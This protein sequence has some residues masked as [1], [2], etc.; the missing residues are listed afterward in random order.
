MKFDCRTIVCTLFASM[1]ATIAISAEPVSTESHADVASANDLSNL[2]R[3]VA[4]QVSPGIVTVYALRGPRMTLPMRLRERA[5][6]GHQ[7]APSTYRP[8][9]TSP[10]D[11]P[12]DQGSGVVIDRD[13][14]VLT[15]SHV[16]ENANAVFVRTADGQK[17]HASEVV[18]D[19][20]SDLAIIK[21]KDAADLQEVKLADS[22]SLGVG[23]WVI[24]LT[25]PYDLQRSV[26]A[27]IINSTQR[28]VPSSPYPLIQNDACTN[29]GSS[30]GALLNLHGEVVGIIEG[31]V[32]TTG[33][34]Q[35]IGLATPIN[36]VKAVVE[37][38]R[39]NGYVERCRFGFET[40]PLT[41]DMAT[42]LEPSLPAGL[43]V[44]AVMPRS[45]ASLAGLREGDVITEFDGKLVTQSFDPD[46]IN[47]NAATVKSQAMK[48]LRDH[49]VIGLQISLE[50]ASHSNAT[51]TIPQTPPTDSFEHYDSLNGLGLATLTPSL[52]R[53]LD[54]P[55]DAHGPL[56]THVSY[57]SEA[58]REG[59]AAGMV[60]ARVNDRRIEYL[61]QYAEI[62]KEL[63]PG[64][65]VLFL[66]QSD[67]GSHLVMLETHRR[68]GDQ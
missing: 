47:A 62:I 58:Y 6:H 36:V 52:V 54:L 61:A 15:C 24:S 2:V 29:P 31:A 48:V 67:Q 16:V 37:Q 26:S 53:E 56:I 28:W 43:Y 55:L 50:H 42:L 59:I 46:S 44:K 8:T 32:T 1:I 34:F 51:P 30:G 27:G 40:Q 41:P 23:D 13:G 5:I 12:D 49:E 60:I 11:S 17:F 4:D 66:L 18:C 3:K 68:K 33:E 39:M 20:F 38:L 10:P 45:P 22:D 19:P 14:W 9:T 64:K 63:E 25:S 21:L 7:S 65:P 35:G 57:D